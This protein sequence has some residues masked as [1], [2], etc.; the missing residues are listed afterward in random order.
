VGEKTL[1]TGDRPGGLAIRR[2][3]PADVA[4]MAEIHVQGWRDAYAG[5]LPQDILDRQSVAEREGQ[6]RNLVAR[7]DGKHWTMVAEAGDRAI[8]GF[9]H[10][11]R[12]RPSLFGASARIVAIYVRSQA[13]RAGVG[14]ALTRHL[15]IAM[16][17][18][19]IGEVRLWCLWNNE[20]TR[21]FYDRLGGRI[22]AASVETTRGFRTILL[23]YSWRAAS[24]LAQ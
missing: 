7:D 13:Q 3:S 16:A 21:R 15:A 4:P 5:L 11:I 10:A 22:T 23:G 17:E 20:R 1:M 14:R 2:A 19:G 18:A 9:I 24:D 8:Q 12:P 6:W